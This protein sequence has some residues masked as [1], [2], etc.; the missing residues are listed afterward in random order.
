MKVKNIVRYLAVTVLI[1]SLFAVLAG[2]NSQVAAKNDKSDDIRMKVFVHYPHPEPQETKDK[3]R[4]PKPVCQPTTND[5]VENY[6]L[7]GWEL[8]TS[9]IVYRINY[10]TRPLN[11]TNASVKGAVLNAFVAWD[12]QTDMVSFS[13]GPATAAYRYQQDGINLVAWGT[14]PNNAIAVTYTWYYPSTGK[15][16]E[17]DTILNKRLKW[18][19][20]L[21]STDCAGVANAYDLQNIMTHENGHW[22]GLD[23]LDDSVTKDLTMYGYGITSELKKDTLGLGDILGVQSLY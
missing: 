20:T 21:Y 7:T 5:Q 23:D 22:M 15:W 3:G 11:L 1:V 4:L 14:V 19:W 8:P 17:S 2:Y 9:T 18:A 6:G 13:E 16:V 10:S 12:D